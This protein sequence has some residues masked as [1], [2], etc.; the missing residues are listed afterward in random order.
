MTPKET[1]GT[2]LLWAAAHPAL[3]TSTEF[4]V[5]RELGAG[6]AQP[7]EEEDNALVWSNEPWLLILFLSWL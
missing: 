7:S 5:G 4:G 2:K 1:P 6:S 3:R